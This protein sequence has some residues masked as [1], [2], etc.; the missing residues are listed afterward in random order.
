MTKIFDDVEPEPVFG[1]LDFELAF[2]VPEVGLGPPG[3]LDDT[4]PDGACETGARNASSRVCVSF[5][6]LVPAGRAGRLPFVMRQP[7]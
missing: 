2:E 6:F 7:L 4:E 5:G 1:G 3:P